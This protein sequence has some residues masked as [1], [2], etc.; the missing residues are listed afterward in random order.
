MD[1]EELCESIAKAIVDLNEDQAVNLAQQAID[2]G[3]DIPAVIEQG[4]GRGIKEVGDLW[5]AGEFFIPELMMGGDIVQKAVELLTPHIPSEEQQQSRD[6]ILVA[7]I[8]GDIHSIGK[9]IV[10]VM[11]SANG[12]DVIDMGVDVSPEKI[13]DEALDKGAKIIGVSALLTTTMLGQK[14]VIELLEEK[15]VRDQFKVI[16][17][18]ACVTQEWATNSGADGYASD[19]I[20]AVKLVKSLLA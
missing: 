3:M 14:K 16:F 13:I 5:E 2:E 12:F 1:Q 18:G 11:L 8:Q 19:A 4:L 10:G 20:S 17:G 6:K 7:T 15:G 9:T